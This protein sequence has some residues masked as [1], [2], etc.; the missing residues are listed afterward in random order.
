MTDEPHRYPCP[1]CR[2]IDDRC[3]CWESVNEMIEE[4]TPARVRS[5]GRTTTPGLPDSQ[6]VAD[7]EGKHGSG[8]T[9]AEGTS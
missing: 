3:K 1:I 5:G 6:H 8:F 2:R 4:P 9:T 7:D